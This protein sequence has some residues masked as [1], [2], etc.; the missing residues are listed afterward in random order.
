LEHK[1]EKNHGWGILKRTTHSKN[2]QKVASSGEGQSP[3]SANLARRIIKAANFWEEGEAL[4]EKAWKK[5]GKEN[6]LDTG[7]K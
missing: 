4:G 2:A 5:N 7:Q 1:A 3:L 6:C